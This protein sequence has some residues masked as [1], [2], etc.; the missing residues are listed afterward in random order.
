MTGSGLR[1]A[2]RRVNC[3]VSR[4]DLCVVTRRVFCVVIRRCSASANFVNAV[5]LGPDP[6]WPRRRSISML[7]SWPPVLSIAADARGRQRRR[8][9]SLRSGIFWAGSW[10]DSRNHALAQQ[11]NGR[12]GSGASPSVTLSR[13]RRTLTVFF[14]GDKSLADFDRQLGVAGN[15][16]VIHFFC[17][18]WHLPTATMPNP[19]ELTSSCRTP[20]SR[21]RMRSERTL[22]SPR[23]LA[24]NIA[25]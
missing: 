15:H 18:A 5:G 10:V 7:A 8:H 12:P 6:G 11:P 16:H 4:R 23:Y 20:S 14:V 1:V 25:A 19:C 9:K 24:S 22:F 13:T 17:P 3:V 2:T 21:L